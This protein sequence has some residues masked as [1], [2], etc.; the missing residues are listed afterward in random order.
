MKPFCRTLGWVFVLAAGYCMASGGDARAG[1]RRPKGF[2]TTGLVRVTKGPGGK[3]TAVTLLAD[4]G[5]VY[6]V[7]LDGNGLALGRT[8]D[9]EKT[10]ASGTV[11]QDGGER[12]LTLSSYTDRDMAAAHEQWRRMRCNYCAVSPALVNATV[13]GALRG[14]KAIDGRPYDFKRKIA[15][16]SRDDRFLWIGIDNAV[17]R[18]DL[19]A[20]RPAKPFGLSDGLPDQPIRELLSDGKTVW[21]AHRGG[22]AA[23]RIAGGRVTP[24][25]GSACQFARLVRGETCVWAITDAGTFRLTDPAAKPGTFPAPPTAER[26]RKK[27][28]A[29]VWFPHW[30]RVTG[31]FLHNPLCLGERVY[32]SSYGDIYELA[33]GKWSKIGPRHW[34]AAAG[35]GRVWML[36]RKGVVEYDP[37]TKKLTVHAPPGVSAGRYKRLL[38]TERA[39]WAAAEPRKSRTGFAGGGLA[40]LDLASRQ[41]QTWAEING[42]KADRVTC[43]HEADGGVWA[44]NAEGEYE[45]KPAHPGMTYVK[46]VVFATAGLC[47]HRY[48]AKAGTW[49]SVPLGLPTFE[50]RLILGQDGARGY[51]VVIPQT[52][53]ALSVGGSR[54]FGWIRL[55]PKKY[56]CGYY[57]SIDQLAARDPA[58]KPWTAKFEHRPAD[59]G[60]N[61]EF[62]RILNISNTGR[63]VLEGVGHDEV[64][65]LFRH[66]RRH[67]AVTEGRV[68]RLDE[69]SGRWQKVFEP[70]FRFYWRVT[71]ALDDGD[72]LYVG[73]DRGLVSR[74]D[75]KTGWF[76][77]L[78]CLDQRS[79]S[80]IA[81]DE[82]GNIFIASRPSPLGI[83]PVHLRGTLEAEEWTAARFDGKAWTK[84]EPTAL[85]RQLKPPWS[86]RRLVKRHRWDKS[87]GNALWRVGPDG[88]R[89]RLYV[90]GVFFPRFLCA[91]PDGNRLWLSTYSGL[92]RLDDVNTVLGQ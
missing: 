48:D 64:L 37:K 9:G 73:S 29:G 44:A 88:T 30:K 90:K 24:V 18:I 60:L 39:V 41:W 68:S 47:L 7:T 32:V 31:H 75:F 62:P 86:V 87:R 79:I 26:I 84:T 81:K 67:W 15:A 12:W 21:I 76:E 72:C 36:S 6:R 77:L 19:G 59:L 57:S 2:R 13:P 45:K 16:W 43:L 83:L 58:G 65:G 5:A 85:P 8:M 78:T 35:A 70:G 71:A 56:F 55:F 10:R 52:I 40:R 20:K 42:R 63:M 53:E 80:K 23:L 3:I 50:R 91:S 1:G 92:L 38:V 61:G 69:A 54:V 4:R 25:P 11:R 66:D 49:Q 33:E 17:I 89:P 34:G 74:L 14:A 46:K 22:V 28:T 27:V 82:R 51:D